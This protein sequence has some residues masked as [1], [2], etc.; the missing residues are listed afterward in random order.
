MWWKNCIDYIKQQKLKISHLIF[1][2]LKKYNMYK[3][4][5]KRKIF[6]WLFYIWSACSHTK[7]VKPQTEWTFG[8]LLHC[9][10]GGKK[11]RSCWVQISLS[12]SPCWF[13]FFCSSHNGKQNV[14]FWFLE[15]WAL[16]CQ[17]WHT[18]GLIACQINQKLTT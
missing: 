11:F 14:K 9:L 6:F 2:Q 8:M 16:V 1:G 18:Y 5:C 10:C 12:Q 15:S 3:N 17:I 7:K 13:F 4:V